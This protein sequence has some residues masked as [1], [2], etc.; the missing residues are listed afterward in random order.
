M[1]QGLTLE[2]FNN[3]AGIQRSK[4]SLF[5]ERQISNFVRD[6]G[7]LAAAEILEYPCLGRE[8]VETDAHTLRYALKDVLTKGVFKR[9]KDKIEIV[10]NGTRVFLKWVNTQ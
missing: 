10:R 8:P 7:N 9:Y 4:I 2:E 1:I 5:A 6:C 3:S